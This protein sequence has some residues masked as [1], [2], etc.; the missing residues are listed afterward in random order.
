[1]LPQDLRFEFARV[2]NRVSRSH[3][4]DCQPSE[5]VD[6]ADIA[7]WSNY[8]DKILDLELALV[9]RERAEA[10]PKRQAKT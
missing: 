2:G 8:E 1:M 5:K 6:D 9:E 4:K 10:V 3:Y 7:A